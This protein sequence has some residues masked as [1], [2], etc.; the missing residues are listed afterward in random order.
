MPERFTPELSVQLPSVYDAQI[1]PD[2][3]LVAFVVAD[4][5]RA[6]GEGAPKLAKAAIYA[7]PAGGGEMMS[8]T[9]SGKSDTL[10]CWS[11]DGSTLAFLSDRDDEEGQRQVY[12]LPRDGGEARR[13]TNVSGD[14]PSPR[15]LSPLQWSA[16]G[17][18]IA[19]LKVDGQTEDEKER[20]REGDDAIEFEAKPRYQRLWTVNVATGETRCVSPDDVQVWEFSLSP[21]G[22]RVAAV[23]S[24]LPY[25]WDWYV[26]RLAV[27]EV[28]GDSATTIYQ[29]RRQVAKPAF[30]P[31]G[32]TIAFLTSN[33]SDRGVDSGDVMVI[34]ATGGEARLLT[35]GQELSDGS[36]VFHPDGDRLLTATNIQ[37]GSG[38][39]LIDLVTED[40]TWLWNEKK[41]FAT[42]SRS[43]NDV[44]AAVIDDP[45]HPAEV[46][47]GPVVDGK[48]Q[49]RQL[50]SV[51]SGHTG[52]EV[53]PTREVFWT[54]RDGLAMQGLLQ[55]PPEHEAGDRLPVV[56]LVHGGP[57]G[58]IRFNYQDHHRWAKVIAD[59]GIAV[60][61]PNYRGST[62]WGLR[63]A[64]TNIGDMGGED[65]QDML[66]GLDYLVDEGIAD[67]DRL[68]ICG[69]SYGGFTAAWA[70]TQTGRFKAAVMGAGIADW[71]SFHGRSYLH[72]WDRIHYG[73]SDP[74][75][76][77]HAHARFSPINYVKN[78]RTPT[79]ILHGEQ[80]WD[81][82]V[83]QSYQF[84]RALKDLGV[85]TELVVYPR[86]PHGVEE[87]AHLV[88]IAR[89]VRRWFEERLGE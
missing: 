72:S 33:W 77:E 49:W 69:W 79:L 83:E 88:D 24:D 85:E 30:S 82:P 86:E 59:A 7:V 15:S 73:D 54:G 6:S 35:T 34:P 37:G 51:H 19:F 21:D 52:V 5:Y 2:G 68:G 1:S 12:L 4:A 67:P 70:V 62:G 44:Y 84:H 50:T 31:G 25:E 47:A 45:D 39:G 18:T 66:A 17:S 10:P 9:N 61:M 46:Y 74:Y 14:I 23:V 60:F 43:L 26:N 57:T 58:A 11:P 65:F 8:L 76:P 75:D 42:F 53:G 78:V 55:M 56:M 3:E 20:A 71:R 29:T 63:F 48:I 28:G 27:F 89:R 40:R 16:D 38:I 32:M 87:Q 80:D 36:A 22:R 41:G 64:E 13:L 81:V